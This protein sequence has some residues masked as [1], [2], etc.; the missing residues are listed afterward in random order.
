MGVGGDI[1][2]LTDHGSGEGSQPLLESAIEILTGKR[3]VS[4]DARHFMIGGDGRVTAQRGT[5]RLDVPS[6]DLVATPDVLV[7][8]EIPP[9]QRRR[10]E[11][12][13]R[14]LLSSGSTCLGA[15]VDAWRAATDKH[16]TVARFL[17]D[18]ISHMETIA[19]CCP[20]PD[21]ALDAFERDLAAT[22]G[23]DR[24]QE[25]AVRTS[26]TSP[27]SS[28]CTT[29]AATTRHQARTGSCPATPGTWIPTGAA[30]SFALW[31]STIRCSEC[32]NM[33]RPTRTHRAT[34]PGVPCSPS[35]P[36]TTSRPN[37][38]SWLSR[39]RDRWVCPSAA[40]T[41]P[42]RTGAWSLKSTCTRCWM[43][44]VGWRPSPSRSFKLTSRPRDQTLA[45]VR[46]ENEGKQRSPD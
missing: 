12:F 5:L 41:W 43:Y 35:F 28:T 25:R 27:R 31:S 40:L 23:H 19:L 39:R 42:L 29:P 34:S 16:R 10:F 2:L 33:C 44:R 17:R 8:Y 20:D 24:G 38:P 30:T 22:S 18:G 9:A 13:Q 37:C 11:A 46:T 32:A 26:S 1:V 4:I 21:S 45:E 7:I 15:D 3:P 36:L 6:E 14:M